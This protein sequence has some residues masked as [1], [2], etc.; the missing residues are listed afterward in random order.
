MIISHSRKFILLSPWKTASQTLHA[1]LHGYNDS[2]Y[3]RSFY[4]NETLGR[5]VN[6][7]KTL[8]DV[9]ALPEGIIGYKIAAFVRNP[10]DRAYSG[11]LQ[12]QRDF[13]CQPREAFEPSWVGDL[14][15]AQISENMT[16]II[17]AA[18]DFDTWIALLPEYEIF[19]SGRN[20]NMPLHPAHYWTHVAGRPK[21]DFVGKVE[22]FN[23]DFSAF[24]EFVRIE[25]P[26]IQIRN[27]TEGEGGAKIGSSKYAGRMS[28]K[29]RDK[30]NE[31]FA[32]D[33]DI[34]NY[35]KL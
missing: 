10:Y 25:M 7:H 30:I 18:F 33:F 21:A 24:C 27:A 28:R 23:E 17:K 20:T 1:S 8:A 22:S 19:D 15:K 16:R 32:K 11:F 29:S 34:F 35:V 4:F 9:M 13:Q 14:V 12:I 5:V 3:E 2:P 26:L 31:L 6:Q